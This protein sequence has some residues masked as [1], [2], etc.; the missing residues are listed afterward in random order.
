MS[1]P[2]VGR[3]TYARVY[4]GQVKAGDRVLNVTTGKTERIG[5]ILQM[6]ANSREEREAIGAGEIAAMVGLKNTSTGD[7]LAIETLRSASSRW[8]SRIR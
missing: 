1:D 4:S 3:L 7:T 2:Y 8:S 6:H 5:R